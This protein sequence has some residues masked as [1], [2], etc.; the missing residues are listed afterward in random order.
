MFWWCFGGAARVLHKCCGDVLGVFWGC[1]E[2]VLAA[3]WRCLGSVSRMFWGCFGNVLG[4]SRDV[5]DMIW[6]LFGGAGA[7]KR[8]QFGPE[9]S[10]TGGP[11]CCRSISVNR[12]NTH[13]SNSRNRAQESI[14]C[15]RRQPNSAEY[16]VSCLSGHPQ[17]LP[18][19]HAGYRTQ[20]L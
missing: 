8:P 19:Q 13:I 17:R 10:P 7:Q 5:P 16:S 12:M 4:R 11:W 6:R 9:W 15:I 18:E 14:G 3:F 2:C 20:V 1:L